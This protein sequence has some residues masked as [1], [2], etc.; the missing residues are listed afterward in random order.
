MFEKSGSASSVLSLLVPPLQLYDYKER[1]CIR[2]HSFIHFLS[3]EKLVVVFLITFICN[4]VDFVSK[5]Q[6]LILTKLHTNFSD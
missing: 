3:F 5:L 2:Q 6:R 1:K 4:L